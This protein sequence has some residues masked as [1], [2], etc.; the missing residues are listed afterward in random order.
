MI[1]NLIQWGNQILKIHDLVPKKFFTIIITPWSE[2]YA[3]ETN[4]GLY[5]LKKTSSEL[6]IEVKV[7]EKLASSFNHFVPKLIASNESLNCFITKD[8]GISLRTY[9]H[10]TLDF[11]YLYQALEKFLNMQRQIEKSVNDYLILGV[12]GWRLEQLPEL[13]TNLLNDQT[14]LS[15]EGVS[16]LEIQQLK[17]LKTKLQTQCDALASFGI[18][19][20]LVQADFHTNNMV[21]DPITKQLSFL[22][23]GEVVITHPFFSIINFLLQAV[24]HF[25]LKKEDEPYQKLIQI[26]ERYWP[27]FQEVL[28]KVEA[29]FPVYSALGCYRLMKSVDIEGYYQFYN[30]RHQLADSL[31]EYLHH[32]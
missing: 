4:D 24:K 20:T 30:N 7:L 17:G 13:F 9:L 6:F 29:I 1:F 2:V 26:C 28:P 11:E 15:K 14:M 5:Y 23:L 12:P 16:Q 25:G 18:P 3:F 31:R 27:D 19:E 22:D 32:A 8:A 21:I 10:Q